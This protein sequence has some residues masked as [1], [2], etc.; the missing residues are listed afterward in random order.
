[1]MGWLLNGRPLVG[2]ILVARVL[3]GRLL[4]AELVT[5][6]F[7]RWRWGHL[8]QQMLLSVLVGE[9]FCGIVGLLLLL[10]GL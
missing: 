2:R 8:L 10:G 7:L 6:K 9:G 4:V 3:M 5:A 1:M